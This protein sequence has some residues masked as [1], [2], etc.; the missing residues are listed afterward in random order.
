M[1]QT[2][3]SNLTATA[4]AKS[5]LELANSASVAE[6]IGAELTDIRQVLLENKPFGRFLQDPSI[7][8]GKRLSALK[9]IFA[10]HVHPLVLNTMGVMSQK[11]RM[12]SL[13]PMCD[14]YDDMLDAQLGKVEV[15]VTLAKKLSGDELEQVRKQISAAL[16]RDAVV[17]QYVD[18][19]I[20]GGIIFR[21]KD[22]LIDGS[23]RKQLETLKK[24][25]LAS[26]K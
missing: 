23:I 7:G 9:S 17:H 1:A 14:A 13:G 22:Q 26:K 11:G 20:I 10:G 12:A 2:T 4:Y 5:L 18:E 15:N 19:S 24:K 25:M 3:Q 8:N 16:K 21:V 6:R